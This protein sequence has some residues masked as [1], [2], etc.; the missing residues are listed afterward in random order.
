M[1]AV[2]PKE[3][4]NLL[5][6]QPR[7]HFCFSISLSILMLMLSIIKFQ[8]G[9]EAFFSINRK[10][11]LVSIIMGKSSSKCIWGEVLLFPP[12]LQVLKLALGLNRKYRNVGFP[13]PQ[14]GFFGT[15]SFAVI[16]LNHPSMSQVHPPFSFSVSEFILDVIFKLH[17]SVWWA[18]AFLCSKIYMG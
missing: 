18:C 3:F 11:H 7:I 14:C 6:C 4:T 9:S 5:A 16:E 12:A 2:F 13:T 17:V 8:S 15:I 10:R 1:L